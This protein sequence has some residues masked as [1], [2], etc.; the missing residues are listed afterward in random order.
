MHN[1]KTGIASELNSRTIENKTKIRNV[2]LY[3]L[4]ST[5]KRKISHNYQLTIK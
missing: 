2:P 5:L 4:F 3:K 1:L